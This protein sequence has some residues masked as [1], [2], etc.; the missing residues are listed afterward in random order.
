MNLNLSKPIIFFD[1]ETTGTNVGKDR[2]V[3]ISLVKVYPNGD[4]EVKTRRINPEMHIPE[5]STA[6]HH[7]TDDDVKD[8]PT[9]KQ[10]AESLKE[11]IAD[12]DLA[13]YNSNKFDVPVLAEEF[14]RAGVEI[15]L[16]DR[17]FVDVQTI[18]YKKEPRTLTA[19]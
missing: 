15:D 8:C 2:I 11:I 16:H 10:V 7:I 19:A 13:G 18:F 12:C 1:L 9:F 6:I 4:E 17:K 3:E 5:D 14:Y